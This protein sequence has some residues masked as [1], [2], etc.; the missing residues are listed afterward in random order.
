MAAA[1]MYHYHATAYALSG[2]LTRPENRLIEKQAASLLPSTGGDFGSRVENFRLSDLVSFE[3]GHSHVFGTERIDDKTIHATSAIAVVEGLNILDMITADRIV[4]RLTSTGESG[5]EPHILLLG[6]R[7][8]NLRIAGYPVHVELDHELGMKLDTFE[9]VQKEFETNED[10]RKMAEDPFDAGKR[11]KEIKPSGSIRCSLVRGRPYEK[12]PGLIRIGDYG[13]VFEVPEFGKIY[14]AEVLFERGRKTLTMLRVELGSPIAGQLLA[15]SAE[16]GGSSHPFTAPGP[17]STLARPLEEALSRE[18]LLSRLKVE[19]ELEQPS[20]SRV[21]PTDRPPRYA[22]AALFD[23]A[24]T[25]LLDSRLSLSLGSVVLLRLDIGPLS[26]ESQVTDARPFPDERLPAEIN[27][28]V[29]LSSTDF[30]VAPDL[31]GVMGPLGEIAHGRFF[32]PANGDHAITPKGSRYLS[33]YLVPKSL[34]QARARLGYY[35]SNVL[36][37]S[38]LLVANV[39]RPGGLQIITDFTLSDDLTDLESFPRRPRISILTNANGDGTHQVV[40]RKPGTPF[41]PNVEG[42]TFSVKDDNI[43]KTIDDIRTILRDR[44]PTE[45]RRTQAMLRED[46]V[47]LAPK[48]RELWSQVPGKN[49]HMFASLE[50]DPASHVIQVSRPTTSGFVF[51]WA[52]IYDIPLNTDRPAICKLVEDWDGK[53]P[54]VSG[55]PRECPRGPH[56]ENVLC[57]FGFWGFRYSIDQLS[58]TKDSVFSIP[59]P[60]EWDF[61]VA[62]TQYGIG[63]KA[64]SDHVDQLR[65]TVHKRF[66]RAKV[67]EGNTKDAIRG[68]LGSDLPLVYFYCHGEK[69]YDASPN[70]YLGVG[71]NESIKATE[72]QDWVQIWLKQDKVIWN[73]IRPLVFINACHSLEIHPDTLVSYLDAFV[74]SARAAGVIGTEARVNQDLAMKVAERFFELLLVQEKVVDGHSKSFSVDE[75]LRTIRLEYL[76]AGNLLGLVYTPYCWSELCVTRLSA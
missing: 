15:G 27:L 37:Q 3:A 4:A 56:L 60:D 33:F 66:P 54:L 43:G 70:T 5:E 58:S 73:K 63:V 1:S 48:G 28:D 8:E 59:A 29:M 11:L 51:P 2:H 62:E 12:F 71:R 74:G 55:S 50:K 76:A 57:P 64:L 45:R 34:R 65:I 22:N 46:L 49:P 23:P 26:P 53:K 7:F 35:Y 47:Q 16:A 19:P 20:K 40:L 69:S 18:S 24:N 38:Q 61:V 72:L 32:L 13:H 75:A 6:S 39:G 68:L 14:F 44:A 25:Q 9:A 36:V 52:L 31:D 30:G 21:R 41:D 42:E 67:R 17:E 10:F